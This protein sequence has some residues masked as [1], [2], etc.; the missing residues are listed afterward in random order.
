MWIHR[1]KYPRPGLAGLDPAPLIVIRE[2][3]RVATAGAR[4]PR[5]SWIV[6]V[7]LHPRRLRKRGFNVALLLAREV[8]HATEA[9]LHPGAL[10]RIRDTPSQTGLDRRARQRNLR[11]AFVAPLTRPYPH[12][13]WLVD[14]VVTTTATLQAAARALSQQGSPGDRRHLRSAHALT[15]RGFGLRLRSPVSGSTP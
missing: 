12:S 4:E 10:V 7:P 3:I 14:D 2:W 9:Q 15:K 11:G 8:A 1:L 13:I 6:P 5:P